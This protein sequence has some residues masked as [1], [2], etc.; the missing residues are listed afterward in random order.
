MGSTGN[1]L[2]STQRPA[3][4]PQPLSRER[5]RGL[6][7]WG[8]PLEYETQTMHPVLPTQVGIHDGWLIIIPSR[9]RS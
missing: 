5:E 6:G 9:H 8:Y 4:S 1:A 3:P 7:P 2:A